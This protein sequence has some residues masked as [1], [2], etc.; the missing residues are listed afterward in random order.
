[1]KIKNITIS[2]KSRQEA[3][4]KF[5]GA[6]HN[7]RKGRGIE[8]HNGLSFAN[9]ATFRNILT[10][11]RMELIHLIRTHNPQSIY[12]LAKISNRDLKSVNT[13]VHL[14]EDLDIISLKKSGDERNRVKPIVDFETLR[15]DIQI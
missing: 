8:K 1:M 4:Q 6:L 3:L 11:K 15:V 2:I 5:A 7:A 13:D 9:V 14:L 10:E 12:E